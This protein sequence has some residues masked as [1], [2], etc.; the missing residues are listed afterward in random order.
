M[1]EGEAP[2]AIGRTS[3]NGLPISS[4]VFK[5]SFPKLKRYLFDIFIYIFSTYLVLSGGVITIF[6]PMVQWVFGSALFY[7]KSCNFVNGRRI[8]FFL[9]FMGGGI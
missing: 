2:L 9:S 7:L 5:S 4:L 8:S 1:V 3:D 6:I